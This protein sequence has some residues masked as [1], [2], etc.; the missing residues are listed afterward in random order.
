MLDDSVKQ[1]I[2]SNLE[3]VRAMLAPH[4]EVKL[5]AAVKTVDVERIAYAVN[6][7]GVRYIGENR[8]N[9]LL[10]KYPY[11]P[12]SAELHFIGRLQ[13]NK[14]KYI[15]DKV[16]M[17][18]S[19]DSLHLAAE[20][21]KQAS[22]R[23]LRMDVLAEI[24]IACEES[25]GGVQPSQAEEFVFALRNFGA[26]RVRGLMA[27]PPVCAD[28][29]D[30]ARYFRAMREIFLKINAKVIDTTGENVDNSI[31]DVLSM[32]MSGDYVSAAEN[33][34]TMVRLGTAV[35]GRRS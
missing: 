9:E 30:N 19:V 31:M 25:K 15:I 18:H 1:Q 32:G 13:T 3:A 33:G 28:G 20:I 11:Y 23:G 4:P 35:F 27:I 29:E 21:D 6:E 5:L 2:R 24:N 12:P 10:E 7:C 16:S 34:S 17:I 8:V 26:L 22:K 14:V